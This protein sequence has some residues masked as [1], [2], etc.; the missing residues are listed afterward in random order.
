M[1]LLFSMLLKMDA[2]QAKAELRALQQELA[3]GKTETAAMAREAH[4]ADGSIDAL[5]ASAGGAAP[6]VEALARAEIKAGQAVAAMEKQN[7]AAQSS[8]GNLVAN[9]NDIGVMIAAGQNPLQLAIQQGT[10][11]TQVIGPMGAAGAAKS[12]GK[13]FMSMLSPINLVTL[14]VIAFGSMAIQWLMGTEEATKSAAEQVS[15]LESAIADMR[16][17]GVNDIEALQEAYGQ[18][19]SGVVGVEDAL[20]RLEA[21]KVFQTQTAAIQALKAE[22]EGSWFAAFTDARFTQGGQIAEL[23]NSE[24]LVRGKLVATNEVKNFRD[25]LNQLDTASGPQAQVAIFQSLQSQMLAATG[26]INQMTFSQRAFYELLV[27]SEQQALKL[28]KTQMDVAK[29]SAEAARAANMENGRMGG[30]LSFDIAKPEA[31]TSSDLA[32]ARDLLTT[33]ET[34]ANVRQLI[35]QYGRDSASAALVRLEAEQA[36]FQQMVAALDVTQ[37]V[38]NELNAAW[39]AANGLASAQI[40]AMVERAMG[41]ASTLQ[42]YLKSATADL[43]KAR[44]LLATLES[45]ANIRQL[46]AQYG[47]DSAS[48]A[49]ARLEAEQAAFQEMVDGLKVTQSVKDE[50]NA[51]WA[52]ANGLASAQIAAMIE[53]ALGPASALAG[54]LESAA[55][56]W[57]K[58]RANADLAKMAKPPPLAAQLAQYGA[59]RVAGEQLLR[60]EAAL[61]GGDGNPLTKGVAGVPKAPKVGSGGGS[62][63]DE[64]DAVDELIKKQREE[65]EV[66]RELDPVKREMLQHRETMAKAT[67][68]ERAEVEE[69]IRT[70][71]QLKAAQQAREYA[72]DAVGDFLEQIIA[73]GAKASDVLRN[74]AAQFLSMAARS[75]I[76]GQGWF[77]QMMGISGPLFGGGS[78]GGTGRPGLPMPYADGGLIG[79]DAGRSAKTNVATARGMILGAGGPRGDE[80]LI[81]ASAGEF[82]VNA[83]A[84]ARHRVLLER[85]N[86]GEA[87]PGLDGRVPVKPPVQS[88]RGVAEQEVAAAL[89]G[90]PMPDL[91]RR[92]AGGRARRDGELPTARS[93]AAGLMLGAGGPRADAILIRAS[94]GEFMVNAD[95]TSRYRPVLERM[96]AGQ[97]IPGYA[98]G[99][100]IGG[101]SSATPALAQG[102]MS[103]PPVFHI[104]L[105]GATGNS[106]IVEMVQSGITAGLRAYDQDVL[107][108]RVAKISANPRVK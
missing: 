59:G 41:A 4:K 50:L 45:E 49:A 54:L 92:Q 28:A 23:L 99:G 24:W 60:D 89:Q 34:E 81:A 70:E 43:G 21:I 79:D 69:L 13:A 76:T 12:L 73:K 6:S 30:P 3:K 35:N 96:N 71:L 19:T 63:R 101:G 40:A 103:G 51:A 27:Q 39:E 86:N 53:R 2:G 22:T 91:I 9:F 17:N 36:T 7:S 108:G 1:S 105:H 57:V 94:A 72:S 102:A 37:Q 64:R 29:A 5:G 67:A 52:A 47:Q 107:P 25:T 46:I 104:H 11:I 61:Y 74:L 14:G 58:V 38:K 15:D 88:A 62:T 82:I 68:A 78:K 55:G 77:A 20:R 18:L 65:I 66:L 56:W 10:Q 33:L 93:Q 83:K 106:E 75:F 26:T 90:L 48:V 8:V 85:M 44:D 98:N 31:N 32:E 97:P 100:L 95:A 87:L 42:A 80:M 16:K 84:T